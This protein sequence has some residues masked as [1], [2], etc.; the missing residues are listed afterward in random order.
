MNAQ[1][2]MNKKARMLKELY[3]WVKLYGLKM[4]KFEYRESVNDILF[5]EEYD[6]FLTYDEFTFL[7]YDWDDIY[8]LEGELC[9]NTGQDIEDFC[10]KITEIRFTIGSNLVDVQSAKA[11]H[12]QLGKVED[13]GF[14]GDPLDD[15][16]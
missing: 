10:K 3:T 7:R 9:F 5:D 2:F 12:D 15:D 8:D 14:L 16:D 11:F 4:S 1:D 13:F 6:Q